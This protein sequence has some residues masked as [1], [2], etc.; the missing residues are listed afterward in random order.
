MGE[1]LSQFTIQELEELGIEFHE[2]LSKNLEFCIT[3]SFGRCCG[4][5]KNHKEALS[6]LLEILTKEISAYV[7]VI[8]L[9]KLVLKESR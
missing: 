6:E 3:S 5:G 7:D 9:I 2:S 8:E 4:V 1:S